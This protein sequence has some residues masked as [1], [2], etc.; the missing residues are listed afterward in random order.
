MVNNTSYVSQ[1]YTPETSSKQGYLRGGAYDTRIV[2]EEYDATTLGKDDFLKL[3]LAQLQNQDPLNPA[4]NTEFIGQLAQFSSLEQMTTMNT[5]LE[6][7]LG[8]NKNLSESI[9]NSMIVNVIGKEVTVESG[10][11]QHNGDARE[12]SFELDRDAMSGKIEIIDGIDQVVRTLLLDPQ[13]AGLRSV[14]WDGLT[15][16][17]VPAKDNEYSYVVTASDRAGNS[18]LSSPV[19]NGIVEGVSYRDGKAHLDIDGILVPFD[20]VKHILSNEE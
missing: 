11:F 3:L 14:T 4:S 18:V 10:V 6:E 7:S 15:E 1:L 17:G 20:R 9:N 8:Y 12:L 19:F 13:S 5:T 2:T 16:I